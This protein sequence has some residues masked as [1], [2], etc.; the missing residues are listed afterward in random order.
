[1][2]LP[3]VVDK[4]SIAHCNEV[5]KIYGAFQASSDDVCLILR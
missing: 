2:F 5:T 4:A 1:M 3:L